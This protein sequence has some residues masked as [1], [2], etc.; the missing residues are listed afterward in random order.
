MN[1]IKKALMN[2]E[3]GPLV[4]G[5]I[6]IGVSLCVICGIYI[7]FSAVFKEIQWLAAITN[8]YKKE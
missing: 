5:L 8:F 6:G 4:E 2:E 3:G 1:N 7:L